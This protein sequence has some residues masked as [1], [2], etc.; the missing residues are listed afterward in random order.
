[1][2]TSDKYRQL[3]CLLS[4]KVNFQVNILIF[5]KEKKKKRKKLIFQGILKICQI[6]FEVLIQETLG[7]LCE[8]IQDLW[9]K[10][11]VIIGVH[12]CRND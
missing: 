4:L 7:K 1:M 10:S 6:Y 2:I 9:F 11:R 3:K 5:R 8:L 12:L